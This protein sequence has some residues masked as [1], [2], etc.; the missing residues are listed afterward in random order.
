MS[1]SDPSRPPWTSPA[2]VAV[3]HGSRDPRS[4]ATV[5]ALIDEVRARRPDLDVRASFLDLSAPRLSD[6][7]TSVAADGHRGAVVVPLLLADAYHARVDIPRAVAETSRRLP[8]L[9]IAIAPILGSRLDLLGEIGLR[10][11]AAAAGS[12]DDPGLGVVLAAVGSSHPPANAV[13]ADVVAGWARQF[14]WH[15][16]IPAFA[17]ATTPTVSEAITELRAAGARRVAVAQ[18]VIAPR[19]L[20]DR[21][22]RAAHEAEVPVAEPLGVDPTLATVVLDRFEAVSRGLQWR[23]AG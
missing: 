16:G 23:I 3:A 10:R 14:R 11:L 17:T 18:W 5:T 4:A 9:A 20:P 8:R 12:L 13:V 7:L 19:L 2:L 1:K 22:I 15:R 21:I 6:A